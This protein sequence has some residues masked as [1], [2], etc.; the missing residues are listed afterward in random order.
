MMLAVW[1]LLAV[2]YAF[3]EGHRV[4][5]FVGCA[6]ALSFLL[7]LCL[8]SIQLTASLF[9]WRALKHAIDFDMRELLFF[10]VSTAAA[11]TWQGFFMRHLM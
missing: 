6:V 4:R 9:K 1:A 3:D 8:G 5:F 7:A 10:S 11:R 2:F